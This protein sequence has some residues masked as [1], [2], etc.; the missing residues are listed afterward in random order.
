MIRL[1]IRTVVV[2][3]ETP[4][5]EELIYLLES[6]QMV[7]ICGEADCGEDAF[8]LVMQ[9][10]PELVFLDICLGD[11]DG[12]SIARELVAAGSKA[13]IV[14]ATAFNRF[15]VE[16]FDVHA[17]DYILKPFGRERVG[18]TL[19]R[20]KKVIEE[21]TAAGSLTESIGLLIEE[22]LQE[23]R[24]KKK[25]LNK[26]PAYH[27]DSL[28]LIEPEDILYAYIEGGNV[29]LVTCTGKFRFNWTLQELKNR[30]DDELFYRT[31]R[32]FLVNLKKV[33][34]VVPW[35]KGACKLVMEGGGEVPVSRFYVKNLKEI[36]DIRECS[37]VKKNMAVKTQ[38]CRNPR[39]Q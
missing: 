37:A 4:A 17:V 19:V 30:L 3:D 27:N 1:P 25:K 24:D 34:R 20:A 32:A 31:H 11:V 10:K 8:K 16:A 28:Y 35:F 15:A 7:E 36:L 21:K 23:F 12:L 2:D 18:K 39:N 13:L 6:T 22:K 5:R 33:N 26:I 38:P 29:I 14:F 9:L